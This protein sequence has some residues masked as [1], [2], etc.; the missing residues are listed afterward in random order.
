VDKTRL[1]YNVGCLTQVTAEFALQHADLFAEQAQQIRIERE[2]LYAALQVM[3]GVQVWP[4]EANFLLFKV[5]DGQ[6]KAVHQA[7]IASGILIKCL[8]GAHPQ[9]AGCLRVTIGKHE[10]NNAFLEALNKVLAAQG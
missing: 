4:S 10:E 3:Q 2:R 1:P 6:A 5:A 9:L 8:D 7:L